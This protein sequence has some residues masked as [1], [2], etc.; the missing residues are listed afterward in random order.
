MRI[1]DWSSDV[2]SSDLDRASFQSVG[3]AADAVQRV[4]RIERYLDQRKARLD[5][6]LTDRLDLIRLHPAQDRD[7][8]TAREGGIEGGNMGHRALSPMARMP[9][10]KALWLSRITGS[11]RGAATAAGTRLPSR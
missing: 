5:Q 1:S 11:R 6:R 10:A 3:E 8:R 7:Q 9:R 2:C 4:G